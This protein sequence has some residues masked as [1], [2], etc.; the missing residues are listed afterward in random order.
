MIIKGGFIRNHEQPA[1]LPYD[2]DGPYPNAEDNFL[3]SYSFRC[4]Y[5]AK[6]TFVPAYG[7]PSFVVINIYKI[8]LTLSP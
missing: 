6:E 1:R 5:S 7:A 4:L 8:A 2:A 3:F